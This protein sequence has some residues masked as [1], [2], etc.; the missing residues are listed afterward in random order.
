LT[1]IILLLFTETQILKFLFVASLKCKP[2]D[3]MIF[4]G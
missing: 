4:V 3:S 1:D 2:M